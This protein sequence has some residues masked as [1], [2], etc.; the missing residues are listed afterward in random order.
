M[1]KCFE[2]IKAFYKCYSYYDYITALEPR[3]EAKL[4]P[5]K[6]AEREPGQ[7]CWIP[8][9]TEMWTRVASLTALHCTDPSC[10]VEAI[11]MPF[12]FLPFRAGAGK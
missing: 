8:A 4:R 7:T 10:G 1:Q 3:A 5:A 9:A 2:T 12:G 11:A 6:L